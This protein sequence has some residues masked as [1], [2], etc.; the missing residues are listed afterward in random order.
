LDY[1]VVPKVATDRTP[2]KSEKSEKIVKLESGS[3]D[4]RSVPESEETGMTSWEIELFF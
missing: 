1:A 2:E 3:K 4:E